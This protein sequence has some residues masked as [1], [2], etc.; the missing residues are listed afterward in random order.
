M[1][2]GG[3]GHAARGR[4]LLANFPSTFNFSFCTCH[5]LALTLSSPSTFLYSLRVA[6]LSSSSNCRTRSVVAL[7]SRV[8]GFRRSSA[9]ALQTLPPDALPSEDRL[10][11]TSHS[12]RLDRPRTPYYF[13]SSPFRFNWLRPSAH[14]TLLC[15]HFGRVSFQ[16]PG[17]PPRGDGERPAGSLPRVPPPQRPFAKGVR[18]D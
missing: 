9:G 13:G 1:R 16:N 11:P 12:F 5:T 18:L 4:L 3:F 6:R 10:R 8:L 2:A 7:Q 15:G 17:R 14:R